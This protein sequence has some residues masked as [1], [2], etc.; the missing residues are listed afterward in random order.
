MLDKKKGIAIFASGSGS[1]ALKIMEYFGDH[2][3]ANINL[4]IVNNPTAGVIAKAT[5]FNIPVLVFSRR[6]IREGAFL[7]KILKFHQIDFIALAGFLQKIPESIV[8]AYN[9]QMLN[10]HPAL[11]PSYGGKGM[12]GMNVHKAVHAAKDTVSGMTI[13]WVTTVYDEGQIVCQKEVK[14]SDE[15]SPEIIAVKVLALE[16]EFFAK[17]IDACLFDKSN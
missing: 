15:D 17:T 1:N 14:L 9:K 10:I 6:M 13:H 8:H 2:P 4:I 11:L 16:H 7:L 3:K 12:Y 5:K